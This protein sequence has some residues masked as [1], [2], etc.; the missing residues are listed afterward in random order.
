[1]AQYEKLLKELLKREDYERTPDTFLLYFL[2]RTGLRFAEA[3]AL[4]WEDVDFEKKIIYTYRRYS[5]HDSRFVAPKTPYSV[6]FVP[7]GTDVVN[8]LR[9]LQTA[10][11]QAKI[12]HDFIDDE[13]FLFSY[14]RW[15]GFP[16][17]FVISRYFKRIQRDLGFSP[18]ISVKGTRHTFAS[19]MLDRNV[20]R[21]VLAQILG[22][23]D[24]SMLR[25]YGHI[26]DEKLKSEFSVYQNFNN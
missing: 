19:V 8:L 14:F 3:I 4:T 5:V 18:V 24:T 1:M 7:L 10:Q 13:N 6:R 21:D 25:T 22:H 26:L 2:L 11:N 20:K 17:S 12:E 16:R 15:E 23:K 9:R